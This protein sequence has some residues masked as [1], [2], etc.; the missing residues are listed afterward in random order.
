[1]RHLLLI[2]GCIALSWQIP[3]SGQT[4][5]PACIYSI[6][7]TF[8]QQTIVVQALNLYRVEQN[9]WTPIYNSLQGVAQQVPSHVQAYAQM[10]NPNPLYPVFNAAA[11]EQL[12]Q[13]ALYEALASV[14][15]SYRN[16]YPN[17]INQ[18]TIDGMFRYIWTQQFNAIHAC[19]YSPLQ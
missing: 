8:F 4:A 10:Q 7:S 3:V 9:V 15:I 14:M 16:A 13:K 2:L 6:P 18:N 12:L 17:S 11:A 5:L 19:L 1:M